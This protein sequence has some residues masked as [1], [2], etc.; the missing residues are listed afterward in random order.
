LEEKTFISKMPAFMKKFL[1]KTALELVK[2]ALD[3]NYL[4]T[5]KYT[6][7]LIVKIF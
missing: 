2:L 7:K 3:L 4:V 1:G 5:K 6:S